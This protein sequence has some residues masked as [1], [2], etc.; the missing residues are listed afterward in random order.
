MDQLPF[1]ES[2]VSMAFPDYTDVTYLGRG[3]FKATY[4]ATLP[5]QQHRAIKILLDPVRENEDASGTGDVEEGSPALSFDARFARE[6]TSMTAVDSLHVA[7]VLSPPSVRRIGHDDHW[8]YEEPLYPSGTLKGRISQG[9]IT[10]DETR[11]ILLGILRGIQ[12]LWDQRKIVHRDI[13]P[14]NVLFDD[15]GNPVLIDLGAAYEFG[16][17]DLTSTQGLAPHTRLYAAPEQ[18]DFRRGAE[19]DSRTDMFP[20]GVIG[21]ECLTG[22]HPYWDTRLPLGVLFERSKAM[23]L[24][25]VE[26]LPCPDE[27]KSL[28]A[29]LMAPRMNRRYNK[30]S[31][32]ITILEGMS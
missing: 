21:Y 3:T 30:I 27:A 1:S 31:E 28:L 20:V 24:E 23:D 9:P 22:T 13:K 7:K 17:D 19:I 2:D 15:C 4:S 29:R 5:N 14:G 8:V 18:W 32:P 10:W 6:I 26:N 11:T 25:T 16:G 12:D